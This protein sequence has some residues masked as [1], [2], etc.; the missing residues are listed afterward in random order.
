MVAQ[1]PGNAVRVGAGAPAAALRAGA[2]AAGFAAAA[3][4]GAI[5]GAAAGAILRGELFHTPRDP[6][7]T[8]DAL[9]HLSDGAVAI[10]AGGEILATGPYARV[11]RA[12]PGMPVEGGPGCILLPGLIDTHVHFPQLAVIGAMGMQLLEWLTRRTLPEEATLADARVARERARTFL[13]ALAASGTTAAL[14]FGSHF[15]S[16]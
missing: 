16:A 2:S 10:S 7:A 15:S 11:R 1:R 12:H 6:F 3:G 9:E 14:V 5:T 4:S 8:A 13:G